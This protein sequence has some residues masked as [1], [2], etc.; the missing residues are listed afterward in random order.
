MAPTD[1][2]TI[3]FTISEATLREFLYRHAHTPPYGL[4]ELVAS[5]LYDATPAPRHRIPFDH[6]TSD[7]MGKEV[8]RFSHH[9][10]DEYTLAGISQ[11]FE[12][13]SITILNGGNSINV[14]SSEAG[15]G[16]GGTGVTIYPGGWIEVLAK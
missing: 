7:A 15:M 10:T 3:T 1:D 11:H 5:A 8:T 9:G 12:V 4:T 14:N 13:A 6:L 2:I 16:S